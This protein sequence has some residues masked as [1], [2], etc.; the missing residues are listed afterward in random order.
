MNVV[1]TVTVDNGKPP[2]MPTKDILVNNIKV[3]TIIDS[4]TNRSLIRQTISSNLG[5]IQNF[6]P[7]EMQGFGGGRV[8]CNQILQ[9][10]VKIDQKTYRA[11][12]FLVDDRLLDADV[13]LGTDLLCQSGNRL[14]IEEGRVESTA[15]KQTSNE[16]TELTEVFSQFPECFPQRWRRLNSARQLLFELM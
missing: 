11:N 14:I 16:E 4:G 12:L 2:P 1:L 8:K 5:T 13:L 7:F 9:S 3:N 6:S 10:N 15:D